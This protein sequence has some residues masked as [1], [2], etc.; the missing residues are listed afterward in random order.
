M[1]DAIN[2]SSFLNQYTILL[3]IDY[4]LLLVDHIVMYIDDSH[5]VAFPRK[6]P[7]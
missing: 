1:A 7:L 3:L 4:I 2:Q 5:V 6:T